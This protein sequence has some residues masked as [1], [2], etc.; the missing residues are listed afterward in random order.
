MTEVVRD[1]TYTQISKDVVEVKWSGLDG[2][3]SGKAVDLSQFPDKTIH[4]LG[5]FDSATTTLYWSNDTTAVKV[6][7]AAGTLFGSKTASWII[8]QDSL[9]NNI[10]KAAAG[11]DQILEAGH[12]FLPV[13]SGGGGNTSITVVITA[14]R[15]KI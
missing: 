15:N 8:A 6:D 11:G 10:A 1:F 9:G 4:V 14:R 13:N 12:W 7:R 5:T 3:D 2:D